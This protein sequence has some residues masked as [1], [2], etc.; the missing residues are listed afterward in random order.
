MTT[1]RATA[2][3]ALARFD[4]AWAGLDKTVQG[5][6]ERDLTEIRDPAGWS[7]K[8]H[9]MHVATWEQA[10]LATLDGRP[11]H[12]ALGLDQST[13]G[14]DDY[15]AINAAIFAATRDR[16]LREVL[17]SFSGTHATT[18]AH[19]ASLADGGAPAPAAE[20]FLADVPGY[21]DHYEQHHGWIR[22]LVGRR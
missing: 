9:L 1:T 20:A 21:A 22:E 7:A 16:S 4:H 11:R 13:D 3:T 2:A 5:L 14:S 18:R 10:L 12:K 15:D 6:S 19:I 17:D 8:D